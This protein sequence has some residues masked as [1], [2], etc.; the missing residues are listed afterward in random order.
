MLTNTNV[1]R[2]LLESAVTER[3]ELL[4]LNKKTRDANEARTRR[5][6]ITILNGEIK[7]YKRLLQNA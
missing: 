3:D 2:V 4:R 7:E 1:I 6:Q 5:R